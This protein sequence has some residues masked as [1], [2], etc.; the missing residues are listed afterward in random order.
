MTQKLALLGGTFDP[1]HIGH[2]SMAEWVQSAL[3][4]DCVYFVPAASPPHKQHLITPAEQRLKMLELA[5]AS[6]NR[7]A[8]SEIEL[9][10]SGP[11]YTLYT[12]QDFAQAYPDAQIWWVLGLDSLLNLHTWFEYQQF[13]QYARLAV[14]PRPDADLQ[15]QDL[16]AY[17]SRHLP[18]FSDRVDWIDMPYLEIAS[19]L[20]RERFQHQQSCRYFLSPSVWDYIQTHNLYTKN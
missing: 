16:E 19:S 6:N 13:P 12:L 11:S 18:M 10:R 1:V 20:I 5:I 3:G 17:L 9:Q 4:L 14:L 15:K 2:L 7:F 8:I